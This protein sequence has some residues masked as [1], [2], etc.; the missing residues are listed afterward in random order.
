MGSRWWTCGHED[1]SGV[2]G[3]RAWPQRLKPVVFSACSSARLKVVPFP[4]V[5]ADATENVL[6]FKR[7]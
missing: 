7:P 1:D 3:G 6:T 4:V 2:G 5:A